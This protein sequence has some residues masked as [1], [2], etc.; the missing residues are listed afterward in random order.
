MARVEVKSPLGRSLGA[1]PFTPDFPGDEEGSRSLTLR[2]LITKLVRE[3]VRDFHL[4]EKDAMRGVLT[5]EKLKQGLAKGKIGSPRVEPQEVDVEEA[6]GQ[7]VQAFEDQ[8]YLVFVDDLEKRN[9]EEVIFLQLDTE[10][11]LIRLTALSG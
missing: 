3:A 10:V 7:A 9:L 6:I 8:L 2:D 11:T 1:W 5:P 4:N